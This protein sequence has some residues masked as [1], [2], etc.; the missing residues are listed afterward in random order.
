MGQSGNKAEMCLIVAA[1]KQRMSIIN[2]NILDV[3]K[4]NLE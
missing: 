4:K 2:V 3:L 1:E